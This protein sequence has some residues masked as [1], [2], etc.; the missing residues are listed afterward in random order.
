MVGPAK[1][2]RA[3]LCRSQPEKLTLPRPQQFGKHR[4]RLG[5]SIFEVPPPEVNHNNRES[6]SSNRIT[7]SICRN[8]IAVLSCRSH[9]CGYSGSC[10]E[11]GPSPIASSQGLE[12]EACPDVASWI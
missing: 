6:T 2:N 7:K 8:L 3:S 12:L 9:H 1:R 11:Q 10:K 4:G 5:R